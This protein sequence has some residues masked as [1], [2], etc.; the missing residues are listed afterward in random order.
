MF[1]STA[2]SGLIFGLRGDARGKIKR[3]SECGLPRK[4]P[5]IREDMCWREKH[6]TFPDSHDLMSRFHPDRLHNA[7]MSV[8][9]I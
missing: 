7:C 5:R 8:W 2:L 1:H 4:F 6:W 9:C 3:I